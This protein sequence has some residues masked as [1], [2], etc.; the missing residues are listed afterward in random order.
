MRYCLARAYVLR[1]QPY[2]V[3]TRIVYLRKKYQLR[4]RRRFIAVSQIVFFTDDQV[5]ESAQVAVYQ[6][7]TNAGE[8][9]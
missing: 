2:D 3:S 6:H 1:I 9:D 5:H 8:S 4:I 7:Q